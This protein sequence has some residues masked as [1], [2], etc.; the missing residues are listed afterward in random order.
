MAHAVARN[1]I[2][3]LGETGFLLDL[4]RVVEIYEHLT[5]YFNSSQTDM[6]QGIVGSLH[7]RQTQI[8]VVDPALL[9]KT[10]SQLAITK[11]SALILGGAEG[12]WALL[13]DRVEGIAPADR[14]Q[15]CG[16]PPLLKGSTG[17]CYSQISLLMDEPM[18][19]FEP[20]RFYG[21]SSVAI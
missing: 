9:L 8:P 19:H 10:H 13:V 12:N 4:D 16:I 18:I 20:E 1:L 2:F 3:R 5:E 21:S 11:K 17:G 15:V 7:F 14:F 6:G